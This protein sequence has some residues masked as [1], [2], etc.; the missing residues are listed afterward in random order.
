MRYPIRSILCICIGERFLVL[1]FL[2]LIF[3]TLLEKLMVKFGP[4]IWGH[5]WTEIEETYRKCYDIEFSFSV[6]MA[7]DFFCFL[8]WHDDTRDRACT[9]YSQIGSRERLNCTTLMDI[10]N[11]IYVT[12]GLYGF[13]ILNRI[14]VVQVLALQQVKQGWHLKKVQ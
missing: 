2:W 5:R 7:M 4:K 14:C 12:A 1:Q 3:Y 9:S 8:F 6:I 11:D 13:L 10:I